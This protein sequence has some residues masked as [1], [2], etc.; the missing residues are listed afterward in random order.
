MLSEFCTITG[1]NSSRPGPSPHV[2]VQLPNFS[3]DLEDMDFLEM[4]SS[5]ETTLLVDINV[6]RL[7]VSLMESV[8]NCICWISLTLCTLAVKITSKYVME[9]HKNCIVTMQF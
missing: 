5:Q 1:M 7:S 2:E 8:Q 3:M 4:T 9:F 6:D